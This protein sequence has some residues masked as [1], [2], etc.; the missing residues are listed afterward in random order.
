M[1][2][3]NVEQQAVV[4]WTHRSLCVFSLLTVSPITP[5]YPIWLFIRL[6]V[7]QAFATRSVS[8]GC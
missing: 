8:I 4:R 7:V 5:G 2:K 1:K 3:W 6:S